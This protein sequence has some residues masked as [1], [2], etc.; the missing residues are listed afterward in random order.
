MEPHVWRLIAHHEDSDLAI[1]TCKEASRI[2]IG[3]GRIGD[4]H[5]FSASTSEIGKAIRS[6]Y[7][8]LSNARLGGPSL[9]R[10][11]HQIRIGDIIIISDGSR[12]R[13]V[14][15]VTGEYQWNTDWSPVPQGDYWHQR[16]ANFWAVAPADELWRRCGAAVAEGESIRWPLARLQQRAPS[17]MLERHRRLSS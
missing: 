10:F 11:A 16:A 12:R 17:E 9:L 1:Q 3:W 4:L 7:P 5:R 2:A 15:E 6:F 13:D 8:K 14:A